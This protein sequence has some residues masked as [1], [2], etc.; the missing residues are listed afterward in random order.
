MGKYFVKVHLS[1]K[2]D[3]TEIWL[4]YH[5]VEITE[6]Y[7]HTVLAITANC[8]EIK[9]FNILEFALKID[10]LMFYTL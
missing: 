7:C 5:T 1:T 2:V 3:F 6:L 4:M 8:P 9:D 10:F